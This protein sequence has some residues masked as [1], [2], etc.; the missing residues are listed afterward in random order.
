MIE[1]QDITPDDVVSAL[2]SLG[3]QSTAVELAASLAADNRSLGDINLAINCAFES[4]H[5]G[6]K[7]DLTVSQLTG[8][9]S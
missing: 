3:G 1:G 2:V 9:Q 4:G 6:L 7:P 8:W 5:I